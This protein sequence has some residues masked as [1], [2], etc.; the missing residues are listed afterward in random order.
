MTITRDELRAAMDTG[1]ATVVDVL[2][3]TAYAQRHLP[4]AINL[5]AEDSDD[6]V[7]AA[8]PEPDA[9]IVTYSTNDVCT[10][11][12]E[13]ATRLQALGYRDVRPYTGGL[14][15]WIAAGLPVERA[16][17]A[18]AHVVVLPDGP[19]QVSGP[20]ALARADGTTIEASD[21]AYLC[22]CG[23]SANKPFCDGSHARTGWTADA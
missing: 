11:T 13:F 21:P 20:L 9:L 6:A 3:S 10:R 19:Y 5:A 4:G 16:E 14:E 23:R 15:D 22:R 7:R 2:P 12:G 1:I 18:S 8:L 17:P